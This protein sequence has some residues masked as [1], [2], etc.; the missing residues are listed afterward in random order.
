MG[1]KRL[2]KALAA[3]GIASRRACEELIFE[4]RVQVN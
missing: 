2:S 1:K 4:G 3:A